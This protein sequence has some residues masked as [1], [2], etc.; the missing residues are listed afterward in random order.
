M[1][2]SQSLIPSDTTYS[3]YCKLPAIR[4]Q[5]SFQMLYA[6][7]LTPCALRLNIESYNFMDVPL[8]TSLFL[9]SVGEW[10]I[11]RLRT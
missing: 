3:E 9:K 8:F 4:C 1:R 7:R 2:I 6:L 10:V 11:E 5:L